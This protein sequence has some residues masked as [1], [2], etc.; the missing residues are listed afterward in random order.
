MDNNFYGRKEQL[1][2]RI[3]DA[4]EAAHEAM[5]ALEKHERTAPAADKVMMEEL[6][7]LMDYIRDANDWTRSEWRSIQPMA[8]AE[9]RASSK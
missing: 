5:L 8:E 9:V 3:S 1:L 4:L 6:E 7:A 2:E